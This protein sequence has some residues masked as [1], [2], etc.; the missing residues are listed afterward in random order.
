M[1]KNS[2]EV[3]NSQKSE[4]EQDL[5]EFNKPSRIRSLDEVT[6]NITYWEND[7]HTK[8]MI[9]AFNRLQPADLLHS[10]GDAGPFQHRLIFII[11]IF[12]FVISFPIFAIPYLFKDP[13]FNCKGAHC[14]EDTGCMGGLLDENQASSLTI[15]YHLYCHNKGQREYLQF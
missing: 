7:Q 13:E 8:N 15:K 11:S 1:A 5:A 6:R 3:D 2:L 10:A 12:C 4:L 9:F 14:G